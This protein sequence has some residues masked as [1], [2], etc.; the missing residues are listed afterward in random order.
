MDARARPLLNKIDL[1]AFYLL[2]AR[3]H[4]GVGVFFQVAG[5]DG[6]GQDETLM[7]RGRR[8]GAAVVG[9]GGHCRQ[10]ERVRL[11]G[12]E[13]VGLGCRLGGRRHGLSVAVLGIAPSVHVARGGGHDGEI[14]GHG[15][16]G[17]WCSRVEVLGMD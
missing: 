2:A 15:G 3:Q 9:L 1:V 16:T 11:G 10:V 8:V 4:L 17:G 7:G 13:G 14:V 6:I 12:L 5:G